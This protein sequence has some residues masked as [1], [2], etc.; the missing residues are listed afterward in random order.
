M[1]EPIRETRPW[2]RHLRQGGMFLAVGVAQL[3]LDSGIFIASTALGVPV[4]AGN[5][6]GR[7]SGAT[8]GFW[9]NGRWTFG[10]QRLDR[11][12][13]LRFAIVWL[14]LTGLST[15]LVGF[16]AA[17]L[18]LHDAWLAKPLVEAAIAAASFF[19]WKHIVFR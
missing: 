3:A 11:R 6:L 8:L 12:H 1:P 16:V 10:Q 9:L 14:A 13:A 19:L 2:Q 15:A 7:V 17:R 5:L 4:V 18:G